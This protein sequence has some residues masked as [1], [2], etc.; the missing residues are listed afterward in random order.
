MAVPRP[1]LIAILGLALC[2]TAL[3]AVRGVGSKAEETVAPAPLPTAP[4]TPKH[5]QSAR[6][7][8][9]DAS[10]GKAQPSTAKATPAQQATQA[11][12]KPKLSAK[13]RMLVDVKAALGKDQVVVLF[14]S[15]PGAADDT[16][17][18]SA[19]RKLRGMKGVEVFSP[20]FE[21]LSDYR[22]ILAG[23]GVSQVPSIVIAKQGKNARLVEGY[24]DQK[25]LRQQVEDALR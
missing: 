19:V 8:R 6:P 16:G 4:A 1:V 23:T 14:F 24:V 5:S 3:I 9:T 2:V 20:S 21:D 13:E 12:S 17:A 15:R 10:A 25:S 11:P 7:K 18:R 22:P